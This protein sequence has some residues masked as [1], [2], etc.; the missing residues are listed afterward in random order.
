MKAVLIVIAI[1]LTLPR[2]L[3]EVQKTPGAPSGIPAQT[4]QNGLPPYNT[5]STFPSDVPLSASMPPDLNAPSP[6]G[7]SLDAEVQAHVQQ[8][9]NTEPALGGSRVEASVDSRSITLIG[10]VG[11]KQERQIARRIARS[12]AGTRAIVDRL[13]IVI[14]K[15]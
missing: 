2:G 6:R 11:G 7:T 4:G 3:A 5:P 1:I 9:L 15:P 10:Y 13:S 14:N 12:Y 8:Q